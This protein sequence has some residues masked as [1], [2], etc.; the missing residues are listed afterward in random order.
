MA[1][2]G[3][4]K[5]LLLVMT[6]SLVNRSNFLEALD[7]RLAPALARANQAAVLKDFRAQ[8]D[9]VDIRK[10][11]PIA[12]TFS[13]GRMA[14]RAG[15]KEVGTIANRALSAAVLDA[16]LG[17]DPVSKPAKEE[18]GKGLAAMVAA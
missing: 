15:G 9:D 2:G 8:F 16:Y 5:S 7:S 17:V 3:V 1:A 13:S 14:T 6:S 10:G 18:F 11:V 12:F 4:E